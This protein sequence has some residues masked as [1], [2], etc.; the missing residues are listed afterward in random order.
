ME[1]EDDGSL[2]LMGG[3]TGRKGGVAEVVRNILLIAL[4]IFVASFSYTL[5]SLME[6]FTRIF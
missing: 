2:P 6:L 3:E 1:K 4:I 5:S